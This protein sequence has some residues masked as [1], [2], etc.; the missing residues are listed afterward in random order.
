MI[1]LENNSII[2]CNYWKI[3]GRKPRSVDLYDIFCAILDLL[4]TGCQW[5][6]IPSYFPHW[7]TVYDYFRLWKQ[8]EEDEPNSL[9]ETILSQLLMV[10]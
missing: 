3:K 9:L 4:K 1:L 2:S 6:L 7:R 8:K 5:R 10:R